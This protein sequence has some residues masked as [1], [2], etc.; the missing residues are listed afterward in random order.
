MAIDIKQI[1]T[2][3]TLELD[4]EE[5]PVND[6]IKAVQSFLGLVKEISKKSFPTKDPSAWL[7]KVY[8]G[9]GGVGVSHKPDVFTAN[10][11]FVISK[12]IQDGIRQLEHGKLHPMFTDREIEY[13]RNLSGLF[14]NKKTPPNIRIFTKQETPLLITRTIAAK[15]SD[16]LDAAY[17]DDGSV[18]GVLE[19]LNAHKQFEFII[20]DLL[21]NRAI[22][23]EVQEEQLMDAWKAFRKRVEVIGKV[24]YRRDGLPISI[25]AKDII[26]FPTKEEIPSLD[27]IRN[28]L[29]GN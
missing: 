11:A 19:K 6:F 23:C 1:T 28:L 24:C 18:D 15:A 16:F 22:K 2:E 21:D 27:V 4:E 9:S 14:K 10:E 3:I 29:R 20:Y 17:E 8:S 26:P 7:I 12:N 5:I 25:K 13:S